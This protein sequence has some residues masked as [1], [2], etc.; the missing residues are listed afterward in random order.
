MPKA[1]KRLNVKSKTVKS[2]R[3]SSK[4]RAGRPP[5]GKGA[6]REP[7]WDAPAGKGLPPGSAGVQPALLVF[8][9]SQR[10]EGPDRSVR[11]WLFLCEGEGP[12]SPMGRLGSSKAPQLSEWLMPI[13][14]S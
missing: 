7:G 5:V 3:E 9:D 1:V 6:D 13:A 10:W 4:S 2:E 8:E 12:A 11:S 14:G